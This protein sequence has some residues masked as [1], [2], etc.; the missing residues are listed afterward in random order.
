MTVAQSGALRLALFL[1]EGMSLSAWESGGTL[2]RELGL[3]QALNDRGVGVTVVSWGAADDAAAAADFPFLTVLPNRWRL[4][5]GLYGR[6]A[7][8]LH[9]NTLARCDLFKSNQIS[10]AQWAVRAGRRLGKPVIARAGYGRFDHVAEEF[11]A[12]SD[13][14]KQALALEAQAYRNA[15]RV[16]LTTERLRQQ[17]I[18]RH[19]LDAEKVQVIPNYV[20]TDVWRPMS[21]NGSLRR[22]RIG[23]VGRL[24]EQKNLPALIEACTGLDVELALVGEGPLRGMLQA[25][26]DARSVDICF[27]GNFPHHELP[28]FVN[29]CT[30]FALPSLYEGHPKALIEA[31]ASGVPVLATKVRG[32]AEVVQHDETGYLTETD[33]T[34]VGDGLRRLLSDADLRKRLGT[35]ARRFVLD[36]YALDRIADRE[37]ALYRDLLRTRDPIAS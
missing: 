8:F 23:F 32:S 31:M 12:D 9:A 10:G 29:S 22:P 5:A 7:G 4:P 35:Q 1:T 16:I 30:V 15:D 20:L 6:I 24:V 26:A 17:A 27:H 37:I 13:V 19:G 28:A 34:S 36:H 33:S 11:G 14:A 25:L 2:A 18:E 3:Y 21:G